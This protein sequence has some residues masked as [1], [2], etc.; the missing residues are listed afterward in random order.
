MHQQIPTWTDRFLWAKKKFPPSKSSLR[1]SK[2][3]KIDRVILSQLFIQFNTKV[4]LLSTEKPNL[5]SYTQDHKVLVNL[6]F[7]DKQHKL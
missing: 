4:H 7:N 3:L 2:P 6:Y 1:Y 5:L